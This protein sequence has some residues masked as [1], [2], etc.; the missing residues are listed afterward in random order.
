MLRR[1]NVNLK[2][3]L[4]ALVSSPGHSWPTDRLRGYSEVWKSIAAVRLM[5]FLQLKR[6]TKKREME[7]NNNEIEGINNQKM[8]AMGGKQTAE[9]TKW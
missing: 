1:V 7:T 9:K 3:E 8:L 2:V 5:E 4:V 6:T